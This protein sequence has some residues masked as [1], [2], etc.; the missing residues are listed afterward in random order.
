MALHLYK[1]KETGIEQEHDESFEKLPESKNWKD[2]GEAEI[3]KDPV[4]G[5]NYVKLVK[6]IRADAKKAAG[7]PEV[8]TA[9]LAAVPSSEEHKPL[10]AEAVAAAD[11]NMKQHLAGT[12]QEFQNPDEPLAELP[13]APEYGTEES[14]S[15][16]PEEV[17]PTGKQ[18][19]TNATE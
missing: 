12:S 18:K 15:A 7:K 4:T 17:K 16:Q 14:G 9:A 1:N 3:V 11:E 2:L 19:R 8:D 5:N 13:K 10:E 6:D